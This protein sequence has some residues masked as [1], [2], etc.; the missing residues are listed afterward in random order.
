MLGLSAL[1]IPGDIRRQHRRQ[2]PFYVLI[3]QKSLE[4]GRFRPEA[5]KHIGP[6]LD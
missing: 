1:A 2:P 3:G 5:S 4:I 6:L